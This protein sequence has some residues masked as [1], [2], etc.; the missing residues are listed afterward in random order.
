MLK[1]IDPLLTP[2]L[3]KVLAEMGH[4]DELVISD[5]NFP[6][7]SVAHTSVLGHALHMDCPA[8]V[9]LRA[10]LTLFPL[11]TFEPDPV[12]S[13]QVVGDPA[14]LPSVVLEALPDLKAAGTGCT[15]IE[16][17]AFYER[18]GQSYAVVQTGELRPYGN[19]IL[20]KG[21]VLG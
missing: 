13:M 16:R 2:K 6:A 8:P 10:I 18:A 3:L 19:F 7:H 1:G 14:Q 21:V 20:R 5:A 11:D 15:G 9:A 12:L 4:G 17:F